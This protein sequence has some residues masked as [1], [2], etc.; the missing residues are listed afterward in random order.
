[1]HFFSFFSFSNPLVACRL[2]EVPLITPFQLSY[3]SFFLPCIPPDCDDQRSC[4]P[5]LP[6]LPNPKNPHNKRYSN[7]T[8]HA[9]S[10]EALVTASSARDV[11]YTAQYT[12]PTALQGTAVLRARVFDASDSRQ[13]T[14]SHTVE[15]RGVAASLSGAGGANTNS[16]P[17]SNSAE[18]QLAWAR[19]HD[20]SGAASRAIRAQL[21][22][23]LKASLSH[24]FRGAWE[25][26]LPA[27][28]ATAAHRVL[29]GAAFAARSVTEGGVIWGRGASLPFLRGQGFLRGS[30]PLGRGLQGTDAPEFL[31][32]RG[33]KGKLV[34]GVFAC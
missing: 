27:V 30:Y 24:T 9:D 5:P 14:A 26:G 16:N 21:G 13:A 10:L 6:H 4:S 28:G 34:G 2:R 23:S 3:Y 29:R 8:G 31:K 15:S 19:L 18:V 11:S 32:A 25:V 20:P 17:T 7:L 22:S 12:H 33:K 1:M